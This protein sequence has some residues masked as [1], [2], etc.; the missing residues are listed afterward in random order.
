MA[1]ENIENEKPVDGLD[2]LYQRAMP[3][4]HLED[5]VIDAL[6]S[7]GLLRRVSPMR[8]LRPLAI[9]AA[10]LLCFAA[11]WGSARVSSGAGTPDESRKDQFVMLLYQ[12]PG[13]KPHDLERVAEYR[14]WAAQ[15]KDSGVVITGER[16]DDGGWAL[17]WDVPM[18]HWSDTTAVSGYFLVQASDYNKALTIARTCPHVKYGGKVELRKIVPT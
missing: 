13:S 11:G 14:S 10:L 12:I 6:A 4:A 3:S 1:D 5:R 15:A 17:S 16:L 8:R 7:K 2:R 9:A 18:G